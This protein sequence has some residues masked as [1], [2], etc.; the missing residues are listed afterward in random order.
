MGP[1]GLCPQGAHSLVGGGYDSAITVNLAANHPVSVLV[2]MITILHTLTSPLP[3]GSV[4][5][6]LVHYVP[7]R[8]S[9]QI[10][11]E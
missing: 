2:P 10:Y 6:S 11:V 4:F 3:K 9:S 7:H 5:F 1:L 8:V